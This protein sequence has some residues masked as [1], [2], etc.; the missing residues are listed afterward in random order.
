MYKIYLFDID[1]T[2][3]NSGGAGQHAMEAVLLE[4]FGCELPA[5][6]D[7]PAA[8]RTDRAI[9]HD[10][11]EL[12]GLPSHDDSHLRFHDAYVSRLPEALAQRKGTVLPG[13]ARILEH[14]QRLE[15]A[16]VGLLTGNYRRGADAKLTHYGLDRFFRFGGFGDRH[17]HRNDVARDALQ[18]ACRFLN[19]QIDPEHVWVIGDT[20][21]DIECAR[22]IG[23]R[24]IAVCTGMYKHDELAELQPDFLVESMEETDQV[25]QWLQ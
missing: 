23:A 13:I 3:L 24:V 20:P 21:A 6:F 4:E 15:S 14:L 11:L 19:V 17:L 22:A 5:V 8:G 2:L 18:D 7:I 16:Q 1:G 25:L 9:T 10:L 12:F